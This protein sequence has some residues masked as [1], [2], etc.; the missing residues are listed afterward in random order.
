[1][2]MRVQKLNINFAFQ[3]YEKRRRANESEESPE[4]IKQNVQVN[5]LNLKQRDEQ[6][7][8]SIKD[9]K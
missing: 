5:L 8:L 2:F 1:M 4:K 6:P 3:W 9:K 7:N